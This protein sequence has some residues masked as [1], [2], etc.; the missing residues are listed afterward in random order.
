[1]PQLCP[2]SPPCP[3]MP[4]LTCL[5]QD[6][7]THLPVEPKTLSTV[8][9]CPSLGSW[10]SALQSQT[11]A[12][13]W[14]L[15]LTSGLVPSRPLLA[16]SKS[17]AGTEPMV[18]SRFEFNHIWH[19]NTLGLCTETLKTIK[20]EYRHY[21]SV[22]AEHGHIAVFNTRNISGFLGN[23]IPA[24]VWSGRNKFL[25]HLL[26]QKFCSTYHPQTEDIPSIR[27]K[28]KILTWSQP[29]WWF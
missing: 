24:H 20:R 18:L 22:L 8:W 19:E 10:C 2:S 16:C 11:A 27:T 26:A 9:A 6:S 14:P 12:T 25:L 29:K 4:I 23:V 28:K 17:Q 5:F 21:S 13:K 15:N 1:M 7:P 3:C